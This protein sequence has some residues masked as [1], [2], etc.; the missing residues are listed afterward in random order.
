MFYTSAMIPILLLAAIAPLSLH[1]QTAFE[2]ASIKPIVEASGTF[3]PICSN[4][5][6]SSSLA[7]VLDIGWAYDLNTVQ[8][9]QLL[10]H[11][12]KGLTPD[13][14]YDIEAKAEPPITESQCRLMLQTLLED[15]F[16]LASHWE[17]K[18]AQVSNLVLARGGP[19][20]QRVVE[21]DD[22]DVKITL[23][24]RPFPRH[25][26]GQPLGMTMEELADFLTRGMSPEPVFDKTGLAGRYRIDLRF[27]IGP[28]RNPDLP[29]DPNLEVALEEQLG[30]KI[31][32]TKGPVNMLLVDRINPPTPN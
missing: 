7:L 9:P 16:K 22:P 11:L 2:V 28:P 21:T 17:P 14:A 29:Q 19:K 15:R 1:A 12:P 3:P 5:R 10:E 23:D 30:L 32:H 20:M 6:F 24:G 25:R 18:A 13:T 31:E 26:P 8:Y 4:G 27:S